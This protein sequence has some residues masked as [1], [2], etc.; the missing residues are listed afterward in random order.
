VQL[1]DRSADP[2]GCGI[3]EAMRPSERGS[4][5]TARYGGAVGLLVAALALR[6]LFASIFDTA[7]YITCYVA[8]LAAARYCGTG[9]A[10]LVLAAGAAASVAL[11]HPFDSFRL[12]LFLIVNSLVIW[13]VDYLRRARAEAERNARL[14]EERLAQ[15]QA[16]ADRRAVEASR[17][18]Q[19]R[20]IVESSEDAIISKDLDGVIRSWN[21]AA[22]QIFGYTAEEAIGRPMTMLLAPDRRHEESDILERIRHGGQVKALETVRVRKDGKPIHVS[23]TVSPVRDPEGVIVGVSHIAR[24][25]T[26]RKEFEEQLRQTQ[27]LE[28]LG[29]LAGGLAHDF[30]NLLT[31]IV[32]NASLAMEDPGDPA[33]AHERLSAILQAS[34]RAALLIRQ[35]LAYAGKGQFV[36]EPLDLSA[37]VREIVPLLRTSIPKLVELELRLADGLP[38]VEA[39]RAQIQQLIMNLALNGAEAM[40]DRAGTVTLAT[41]ARVT[42]AESQVLLEVR[43]TG[44]GMTDDVKARIFDPFFTTKFTGRGLGLSAVMGIIRAH[45]GSISVASEP[46][47]G[48]AFTVVLPACSAAAPEA[49]PA[50]ETELRGYGKILVVDDEELVRN[51]ARFTLERYG[52]DVEIACDGREAVEKFAARPDAF[53]AVLLDLTMPVMRGEDALIAIRQLRSDVPV[54]V[55]SGYAEVDA[56]ARFA[57]LAPAG[58]LQKPYT[59][60]ALARKTK[61]AVRLP[62]GR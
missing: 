18:A 6:L 52:Y 13:V 27:K 3:I 59:A 11:A 49:T 8:T 15:L 38:P 41:S 46:G 61:Q 26:E 43:D 33:E 20:A 57:D 25:I 2:H 58:F 39:D 16:E 29:V 40:G 50:A 37:Q 23:I 55:S 56:M 7:P 14:A 44:V 24:D 5:Q 53:A 17:A 34:E 54:L 45:R 4:S 36:I 10:V 35:M 28:S 48:T 51:M 19:L 9:P 12:L 42:D 30:N 21:R 60:T 31:G 22:A 62:R 32:G 47:K 1:R